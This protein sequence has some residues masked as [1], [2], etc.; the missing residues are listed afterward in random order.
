MMPALGTALTIFAGTEGDPGAYRLL[1]M[2]PLVWI[3]DLSYGWYLWHWPIIVAI[4]ESHYAQSAV[5]M[6][7]GIALSLLLAWGMHRLVE[8]PIRQL[9]WLLPR[10]KTSIAAGVTITL[11]LAGVS[12]AGREQAKFSSLTPEQAFIKL[13]QEDTPKLL[14]QAGC[15]AN[16]SQVSIPKNCTFGNLGAQN[17]IVLFGDS[18]AEQWFPALE[19]LALENHWRLISITKSGCPAASVVP[20]LDNLRRPY[21]ECE[22]W[23]QLAFERIAELRPSLVVVG[24][25]YGYGRFADGR[26]QDG[27][28]WSNGIDRTLGVLERVAHNVLLLRDT[29]RPSYDVP[30]CLSR[31]AAKGRM[32]RGACQ[33]NPEISSNDAIFAIEQKVVAAHRRVRTADLSR[34]ICPDSPC[35]VVRNGMVLFS[36]SNHMTSRFSASQAPNL[37]EKILPL[38]QSDANVGH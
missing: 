38:M 23:R 14:S 22:R 12:F 2:G 25:S 29:P 28:E 9:P 20:Y 27:P 21:R 10:P 18:H 5:L 7:A 13:A 35:S 26:S 17:A 37:L 3:G 30:I 24:N 36:D 1:R 16:V 34:D 15:H 32:Y 31:A 11:L 6:A 4:K 33:F 19:R 8:N